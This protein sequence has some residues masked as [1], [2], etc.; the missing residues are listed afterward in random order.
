[1]AGIVRAGIRKPAHDRTSERE[2]R[3]R[4]T[5]SVLDFTHGVIRAA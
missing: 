2:K 3:Q 4:L 1:M 5:Q